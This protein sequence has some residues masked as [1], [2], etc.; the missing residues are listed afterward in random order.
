MRRKTQSIAMQDYAALQAT[1]LTLLTLQ[2][3]VDEALTKSEKDGHV[4]RH[5]LVFNNKSAAAR[6]SVN[7]VAD[8]DTWWDLAVDKQASG[9]EVEWLDAEDPLFKVSLDRKP[10]R[11]EH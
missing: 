11:L 8:R 4:V 10:A 5:V 1:L 3:I 6:N 2:G 9:C 7:M